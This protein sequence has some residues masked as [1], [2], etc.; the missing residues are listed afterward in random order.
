M[1]DRLWYQIF[2]KN[3]LGIFRK[4]NQKI[5][6]MQGKLK[7]CGFFTKLKELEKVLKPLMRQYMGKSVVFIKVELPKLDFLK[8]VRNISILTKSPGF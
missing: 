8:I 1:I 2:S 6:K 3:Y 4:L 5:E 7:K